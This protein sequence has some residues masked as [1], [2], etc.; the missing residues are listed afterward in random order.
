MTFS[1]DDL[2]GVLLGELE[3]SEREGAVIYLTVEPVSEGAAVIVPGLEIHVP[4]DAAL[5]FVDREPMANWSHSARYV[6][7]SRQTGEVASIEARLPPFGPAA[8]RQWRVARKPPSVPDAALPN[9][10]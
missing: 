4:W 10:G 2:L 5:A 7:L 9:L 1:E 8:G 6:L 3:E